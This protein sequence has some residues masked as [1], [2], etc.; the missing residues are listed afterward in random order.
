MR[1]YRAIGGLT[2][3]GLIT[4]LGLPLP[5][6]ASADATT[7]YVD[8]AAAAHCSDS[9][10][11]TQAQ[12]YC[13]IQAAAD[14]AQP[15]QTVQVSPDGL[16]QSQVT[17]THSGTPDQPITFSGGGLVHDAAA[18]AAISTNPNPVHQAHA[19]AVTSAH[20][21][22][23]HGF[24]VSQS[25]N[26][27]AI[28]DSTRIKIDGNASWVDP[29]L[30]NPTAAVRVSG[31]SSD[32]T[33]SRNVISNNSPVLID[34]GSQ[35]TTVVGNDF[36]TGPTG[37]LTAVGAP[38]TAVV[39]NTVQS[40][41][42]TAISLTGGSTGAVV[43]NNI[44][45]VSPRTTCPAGSPQVEI[46][47]S[48]DS[49]AQSRT[50]YNIAHPIAGGSA[51]SWSG[52]AYPTAKALNTATGQAAHD[53]DA[54]PALQEVGSQ[55]TEGSPA[56]DSA[57]SNAPGL[58]D[59][60]LAGQA[61]VDDPTVAN[62]G[63]GGTFRDRGAYEY[64]GLTGANLDVQTATNA[65]QGPAP[66]A[67]TLF[68]NAY[69][70][71]PTKLTYSY[72]FGDGSPVVVS[73]ATSTT[74]S[75]QTV[76]TYTPKV[77]VTDGL[78]GRVTA[79][80]WQVVV[81]APGPIVP[82]LTATKQPAALTYSFSTAGSVVP[83]ALAING[84]R[85]D[86]GDG[87]IGQS[88]GPHTFPKPGKYTVTAKL[89]DQTGATASTSVQVDAEYDPA[90]FVPITPT[91]VMDTRNHHSLT[92]G[93]PQ[94]I[95]TGAPALAS[96]VVLNLTATNANQTGHLTVFPTGADQPSTSNLNYTAGT[97]IANLVTVPLGSGGS[98]QVATNTGSVDVVA[99]VYGYYMPGA[100][101]KFTPTTPA[102]I[103]DTRNNGDAGKL[104][105]DSTLPLQVTGQGSVP[106]NATAVVLN[107][108]TTEATDVS[109]LA[110]YPS[111][112]PFTG[113]SN[114]NFQPG[115]NTPNQ[116][117]VPVGP[118]GKVTIYNH[119]GSV[120]VIAD[121][122][123]YY[124]PDGKGL[125]T[126]VSPTRLLDTRD[127]GPAAKPGPG[128]VTAFGG[129]PTG[130]TAAALNVT[131]TGGDN[132]GF[133]T[134]YADGTPRP[135]SSN[136]NVVPNTDIANHAIAQVGTDG[137]VDIYNFAGHTDFVADLFG[138]FTNN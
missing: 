79:A 38:N 106:S 36:Y 41:C 27:I 52:T 7:L 69:T 134:V 98:L 84:T 121:V 64:E 100:A 49:A 4:V 59:T 119:S 90:G 99:D 66:L 65:P 35:R 91:R 75:Y 33:I 68:V 111:G 24:T 14:A 15:G 2:A 95:A 10:T 43:E 93:T 122:F 28:T 96:A 115:R 48:A 22:V 103:L 18:H 26:G 71:W 30:P 117:I 67:T 128:S 77:T 25:A 133:L 39:N 104:G 57:D 86:Y 21:I 131:A 82:V 85:L 13:T 62:T 37:A 29:A 136:L 124:S 112:T 46:A 54:D 73:S 138:Y 137:K 9:G 40:D 97:N 94:Y 105:P 61:P 17:I 47:V 74:H 120:H 127:A 20:D 114:L 135:G 81:N 125:F 126:P 11:G 23:I 60:D 78:G 118:D 107:L 87:T 83:W 113:T 72:D 16:Y 55:L 50:D 102:R 88:D 110:A 129:I 1:R 89:T 31:Q 108:T 45:T 12:P 116:V 63:P 130:A 101:S 132:D 19:F 53:I 44:F 109:Y 56:I 76:G 6:A 42:G 51:Y 32:V 92:A 8:N 5:S 80:N 34:A 58:L 70:T 123:G 3:A